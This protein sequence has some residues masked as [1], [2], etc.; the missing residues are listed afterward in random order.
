MMLPIVSPRCAA[1]RTPDKW[2]GLPQPSS[3]KKTSFS[4]IVPV[5]AGMH[6]HVV[7]VAVAGLDHPRRAG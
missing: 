5:L 3:S 2:S 4:V 6:Q 1:G 7:E